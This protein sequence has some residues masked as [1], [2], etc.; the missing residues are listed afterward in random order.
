MFEFEGDHPNL[1]KMKIVQARARYHHGSQSNDINMFT[2]EK[3]E[4]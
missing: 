3:N 2:F 1:S 4:K